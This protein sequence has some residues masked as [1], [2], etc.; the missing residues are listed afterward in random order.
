ML[1][2]LDIGNTETELGLFPLREDGTAAPELAAQWRISTAQ[3]QLPTNTASWSGSCLPC[4]DW[5]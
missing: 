4:G 1:L 3:K 5:S 2:V